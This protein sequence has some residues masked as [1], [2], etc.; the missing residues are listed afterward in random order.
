VNRG[1]VVLVSGG[2]VCA[3][4]LVLLGIEL[5]HWAF[6][7]TMLAAAFATVWV[8]PWLW[9]RFIAYG[10]TIP[11]A[12]LEEAAAYQSAA[13]LVL[14]I[15]IP[16]WLVEVADLSLPNEWDR[17]DLS[18]LFAVL[19]LATPITAIMLGF[20]AKAARKKNT[21]D[22]GAVASAQADQSSSR[23]P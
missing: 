17:F 16:V 6:G 3:I 19:Q 21:D 10:F 11:P 7:L 5:G 12:D 20:R 23:T 15:G 8:S 13:R 4:A 2:V 14:R 18:W 9:I 1:D 22:A